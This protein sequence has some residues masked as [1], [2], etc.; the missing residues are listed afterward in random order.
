[1]ARQGEA[2]WAKRGEAN[3]SGAERDEATKGE[4]GEAGAGQGGAERSARETPCILDPKPKKTTVLH[5]F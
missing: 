2:E 1:M 5:Y 3:R 4:R